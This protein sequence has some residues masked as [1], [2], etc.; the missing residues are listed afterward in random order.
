MDITFSRRM[1]GDEGDIF[2]TLNEQKREL[3]R[4]GKTLYDL[5]IGT[6]D[7]KPPK[8]V[9]DAV[10]KA[11]EAPENY[12]YSIHDLPR[13]QDALIDYYEKRYQVAL[14]REEITS[15]S[16]TQEG[17]AHIFFTI[18]DPGDYVLVP[19]PGYPIFS[20]GPWLA[21][22]KTYPYPLTEDNGYLPDFD[23]IPEEILQKAKAMVV[24]YPL[25][26]LGVTAPDTF[27][28]ALIRFANEHHIVIIH[29]NAYS[30][31]IFCRNQGR[32]FLSF[33]GAKEV[34]IEFFSLSKSF[35]LTGARISFALGNEQIIR[36]F[37]SLRSRIDY[38]IFLPV[39]YGAI[40]ALTGP[41]EE[42]R[43]QCDEYEARS[44]RLTGGFRSIGWEVPDADGSMFVW[45]KIPDAYEDS[46]I[47]SQALMEKAGVICTPGSS[48]GSFG[49]RY[50][51]FALVLPVEQID[52]VI[53]AIG[54]SHVI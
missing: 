6:P 8:Y 4:A 12:K 45:A 11:C 37:K 52:A 27:Y 10:A 39:Q 17:L 50:V 38:G 42:V 16:G 13:L 20:D 46:V 34:G 47:F 26:P 2:H 41:M 51:R 43:R 3:E 31:I 1:S 23:A 9:I 32:S 30:D 25:N 48:F 21:G 36:K 54:S 19:D 49:K 35:N 24:S 40:A 7:F 22:A 33:E 14:R 29:D 15:V 28:P 5:S 53:E 44:R 18:C